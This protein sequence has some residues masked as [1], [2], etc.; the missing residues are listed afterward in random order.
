MEMS[1]LGCIK[2]MHL[3]H[4]VYQDNYRSLPP[5]YI[6]LAQ[7]AQKRDWSE[8]KQK[9]IGSKKTNNHIWRSSIVM[10]LL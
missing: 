1:L 5:Y 7:M 4:L 9:T 10:L 3:T 2:P 6:A 8:W